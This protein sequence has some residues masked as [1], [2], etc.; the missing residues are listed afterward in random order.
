M[1]KRLQLRVMWKTTHMLE[2]SSSSHASI[3]LWCE[4][5]PPSH[6]HG[7]S[8]IHGQTHTH[9][10]T[11]RRRTDQWYQVKGRAPLAHVV[12][13]II[14]RSNYTW[15]CGVKLTCKFSLSLVYALTRTDRRRGHHT[16]F[17]L[18]IISDAHLTA[19][20]GEQHANVNRFGAVIGLCSR[21]DVCCVCVCVCVSE[22]VWAIDEK[23]L[24]KGW[25]WLLIGVFYKHWTLT[26]WILWNVLCY[27]N[28]GIFDSN[29]LIIYVLYLIKKIRYFIWSE[30]IDMEPW[31]SAPSEG[32]LKHVV[33]LSVFFILG[34]CHC[35]NYN[36]I[37]LDRTGKQ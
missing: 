31:N 35:R 27:L 26:I 9:T 20:T 13:I 2:H 30:G 22:L 18:R 19:H 17:N 5:N 7:C 37:A 3:A 34:S 23:W 11:A 15:W 21:H 33:V 36:Q 1:S 32:I 8:S 24:F 14:R 25:N 28:R 29:C 6:L 12:I 10:L 4:F 16:Y